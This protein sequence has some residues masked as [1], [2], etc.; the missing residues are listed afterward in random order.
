MATVTAVTTTGH[1]STRS[2]LRSASP[3][4]SGSYQDRSARPP[5]RA[6]Q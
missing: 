3:A 2:M 4:T 1:G 5:R 6:T